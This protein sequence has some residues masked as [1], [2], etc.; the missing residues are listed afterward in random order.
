LLRIALA[1]IS[2]SNSRKSISIKCHVLKAAFHNDA[3]L[4]ASP[5]RVFQGTPG[6]FRGHT[7]FRIEQGYPF[8]FMAE[9]GSKGGPANLR[10]IFFGWNNGKWRRY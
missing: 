7:K 2:D 8:L 6:K 10:R 4:S 5:G 9:R 3:Q 1:T